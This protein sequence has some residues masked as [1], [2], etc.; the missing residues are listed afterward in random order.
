MPPVLAPPH[1]RLVDVERV[2]YSQDVV[3][4]PVDAVTVY[5]VGCVARAVPSGVD[6]HEPV[7]VSQ[8]LD[9]AGGPPGG[10]VT[11]EAVQQNERRSTSGRLEGDAQS[12]AAGDVH[13]REP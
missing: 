12:V 13:A 1:G 9:M 10:P 7:P 4:L 5:I 11:E 3:H 8:G 2:E 6:G